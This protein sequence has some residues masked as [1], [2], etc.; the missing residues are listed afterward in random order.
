MSGSIFGRLSHLLPSGSNPPVPTTSP[1]PP[2]NIHELRFQTIGRQPALLGRMSQPD[3]TATHY[4]SP[5]PSPS[6][7][8]PSATQPARPSLYQKLADVI[9]TNTNAPYSSDLSSYAPSTS[10][11][12]NR[13]TPS[14]MVINSHTHIPPPRPRINRAKNTVE[15]R[16]TPSGATLI[17]PIEILPQECS[18]SRSPTTSHLH[19]KRVEMNHLSVPPTASSQDDV[20]TEVVVPRPIPAASTATHAQ[21]PSSE[22]P[23]ADNS[24]ATPRGSRAPDSQAL[25]QLPTPPSAT[26]PPCNQIVIPPPKFVE[27]PHPSSNSGSLVGESLP[28]PSTFADAI[29]A[30][31]AHLLTVRSDLSGAMHSEDAVCTPISSPGPLTTQDIPRD[32]ESQPRQE[33]HTAQSLRDQPPSSNLDHTMDAE[34]N[35]LPIISQYSV[36]SSQ[37]QAYASNFSET[38]QGLTSTLDALHR[39]HTDVENALAQ[40]RRSLAEQRAVLRAAEDDHQAHLQQLNSSREA[41]H[42]QEV[43]LAALEREFQSREEARNAEWLTREEKRCAEMKAQQDNYVAQVDVCLREVHELKKRD[44]ER[45]LQPTPFLPPLPT[46]TNLPTEVQKD[47]NEEEV[48]TIKERNRLF[49][50]ID[51]SRQTY[52][53]NV[54]LLEQSTSTL[55][56]LQEEREKRLA[57]EARQKCQA[58]EEERIR[59]VAVEEQR[60]HA[61][62]QAE[63]EESMV[64][65]AERNRM[66]TIDGNDRNIAQCDTEKPNDTETQATV[67]NRDLDQRRQEEFNRKRAEVMAQKQQANAENAAKIRAAREGLPIALPE[68]DDASTVVDE[69]PDTF[70]MSSPAAMQ[71]PVGTQR[72]SPSSPK[73]GKKTTVVSGGVKLSTHQ[74][75]SSFGSTATKPPTSSGHARSSI[76]TGKAPSFVSA[77]TEAGRQV[78]TDTPLFPTQLASELNRASVVNADAHRGVAPLPRQGFALNPK[79]QT[80]LEAASRELNLGPTPRVSPAQRTTNLRH[81]KKTRNYVEEGGG[82][83][84]VNRGS[85]KVEDTSPSLKQEENH[86]LP[87]LLAQGESRPRSDQQEMNQIPPPRVAI[88]PPP[89]PKPLNKQAPTRVPSAP[90]PQSPLSISDGVMEVRGN[91]QTLA[92]PSQPPRVSPNPW[93]MDAS[94]ERQEW[95]PQP[96]PSPSPPQAVQSNPQESSQGHANGR[97]AGL[98]EHVEAPEAVEAQENRSLSI[99]QDHARHSPKSPTTSLSGA[100]RV[101]ER[102]KYERPRYTRVD[103]YSPSPRLVYTRRS[104]QHLGDD[105]RTARISS[106][107]LPSPSVIGRKRR[108]E[109][110]DDD[111]SHRSRRARKDWRVT[112]N[113][114][115]GHREG[116]L[117]DRS[118]SPSEYH[119]YDSGPNDWAPA[120]ERG[121]YDDLRPRVVDNTDPTDRYYK[122]PAP[123]STS[124]P[125]FL[126]RE[127]AIQ[128]DQDQVDRQDPRLLARMSDT[129]HSV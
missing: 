113:Y 118:P 83:R 112:D 2:P 102:S 105:H 57:E 124:P 14:G 90:D 31:E 18:G 85:V 44:A 73:S 63:L 58:E 80:L 1:A 62:A 25:S 41:L 69:A 35:S 79:S 67:G 101:R 53:Q 10:N 52:E 13:S 39:F 26:I 55:A 60:K 126:T 106:T 51:Q 30:C 32:N 68:G 91:I 100:D 21:Q 96:T 76:I 114:E 88:I 34:E 36:L 95:A 92:P 129:Q 12:N 4:H 43:A 54:T 86:D 22:Q 82:N 29:S 9:T 94:A 8:V 11:P 75:G 104:S 3:P 59:Q 23:A 127:Q 74:G 7:I 99:A 5:S 125:L 128:Q 71:R 15:F 81:L 122:R 108:S 42:Q 103:H 65:T 98:V 20:Q 6:A 111:Y 110:V 70:D 38:A 84:S 109:S 66:S 49:I 107:V 117:R 120:N 93:V 19:G 24:F 77:S 78:A 56:R 40:Q 64:Q 27:E 115:V 87:T 37:F 119:K 17:P 89:R 48:K 72:Y 33:S 45:Y 47:M 50:I 123:A 61:T 46:H 16:N 121:R 28:Q 97:S 116:P